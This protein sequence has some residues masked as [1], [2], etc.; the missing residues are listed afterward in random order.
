[1]PDMVDPM[2]SR[3]VTLIYEHTTE[4]TMGLIIN[5]M[6]NHVASDYF[7]LDTHDENKA[8]PMHP[9]FANAPIY[10][11]G[12]LHSNR[13]FVLHTNECCWEHDIAI[14][15]EL[16]LTSNQE[17]IDDLAQG[18]GPSDYL[19]TLG[20]AGWEAGQLE[21]ELAENAWLHGKANAD[22]LF[23]TPVEKRWT[24]AAKALGIDIHLL[25]THAGHA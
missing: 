17:I 6:T 21:Q 24:T 16:T 1:M 5:R 4:G 15:K 10:F 19:I 20:Y 3:T 13:G 11:G 12:P 22:M 14:S 8:T 23:N 2:F 9:H 25:D 7:S 18:K